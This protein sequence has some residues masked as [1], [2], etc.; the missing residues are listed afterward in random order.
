MA[1]ELMND[2]ELLKYFYDEL[3]MT[4]ITM[5]LPADE[6]QYLVGAGCIGDE[7]LE[8]F[9]DFYCMRRQ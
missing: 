2:D 5:S 9:D 7:I 3:I 1:A 8:V 6:Q 4:L